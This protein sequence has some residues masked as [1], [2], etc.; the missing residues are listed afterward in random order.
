MLELVFYDLPK[1]SLNKFYA[2]CHWTKRKQ[3]KDAYKLLN[4]I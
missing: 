3:L 2:G 1:V 4:G